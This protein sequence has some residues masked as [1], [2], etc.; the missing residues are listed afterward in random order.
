MSD[1]Q[2]SDQ[3]AIALPRR[4]LRETERAAR[5]ARATIPGLQPGEGFDAP[6]GGACRLPYAVAHGRLSHRANHRPGELSGGEHQRVGIVRALVNNQSLLLVDEP[7]AA[8]D[9]RR[10]EVVRVLADRAHDSNVA[11]VMVTR[12]R[13]FRKHCDRIYAMADGR[14]TEA[15]LAH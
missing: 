7:T 11:V 13:D 10:H 14:L 1:T 9:R 5:E 3:F 8:F 2:R 6:R 15:V 4:D 12:D